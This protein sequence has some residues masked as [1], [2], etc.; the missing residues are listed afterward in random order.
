M[1]DVAPALIAYDGSEASRRAIAGAAPLLSGRPVLV[2]VARNAMESV[3]ARI[4]GHDA[5]AHEPDDPAERAAVEGV[6]LARAAGLDA[7][8][9]VVGGDG[10]VGQTITDTAERL[11]ASLIVLGSRANHGLRSLALGSVS[12][13]VVHD[14]R[15]PTLV[16]PD[17]AHGDA[18]HRAPGAIPAG[19]V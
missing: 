12:R 14:A 3:A 7:D 11:G 15:R 10:P 6:R 2:V 5:I 18:A 4:E 19:A 9:L 17:R 1:S 13:H 8:G 16:V